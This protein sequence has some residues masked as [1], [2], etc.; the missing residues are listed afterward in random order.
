VSQDEDRRFIAISCA[1]RGSYVWDTAQDRLLAQLPSATRP[2]G[3]VPPAFPVV[4]AAGDLAAI[5]DGT[6]VVIYALP[7]GRPVRTILHPAAV[8]AVAFA[9][10]GHD[11][12][13]ASI[14]G[15]LLVTRDAS[16]PFALPE[17]GGEIDAVGFVPDGRVVVAGSRLVDREARRDL[18]VPDG[19]VVVA[20]S[21]SEL[22][23]Y[24]PRSGRILA[25]VALAV[26]TDVRAF[27][28][29]SDSRRLITI[30]K[31]GKPVPPELWD[32]EH[33]RKI[34]ALSTSNAQ[35][36]SAHF[37]R[38]DTQILTAGTDGALGLWDATTGDSR[39][40]N[41]GTSGYMSEVALAPGG[42]T[43]VM[44]TRDG[45]LRFWDVSSRRMIWTLR[46][47]KSRIDGVHFEGADIVTR[48]STGEISRWKL[49]THLSS[50]DPASF[51]D[52]YIRCLP[53]RFDEET[54]GLI[55]QQQPCDIS[56]DRTP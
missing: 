3:E 25:E 23:V 48:S 42:L 43:V 26:K 5:A 1:S 53:L 30:A 11:L 29:S 16:D 8:N 39:Q 7:G 2:P 27:R 20:A 44:A 55:D 15:S 46:A 38:G 19:R 28:V 49:A 6:A 18:D 14:D 10:T 24:D 47:H 32:L 45:W 37:V 33:Y 9:R 52:R 51:F 21:R 13:S 35:V 17:F 22:R 56:A 40:T 31:P 41:F 12:I 36:L 4:S 34:R 54:G 50:D